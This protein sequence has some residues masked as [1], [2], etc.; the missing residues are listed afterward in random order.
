MLLN[1]RPIISSLDELTGI[2]IGGREIVY[3][4]LDNAV[5]AWNDLHF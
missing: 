5:D 2:T 1:L 3:E 4:E